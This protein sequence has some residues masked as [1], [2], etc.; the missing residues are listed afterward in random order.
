MLVREVVT[1]ELQAQQEDQTRWSYV[2]REQ[3][4][5]SDYTK[6]VIETKE[7]ALSRIIAE[8]Q[9][10]LT[11]EQ[12]RR[13]DQHLHQIIRNPSELKRQKQ[14]QERDQQKEQQLLAMMPDGFLYEYEGNEGRDVS[15]GFRPN[16]RFRPPTRESEVFHAMQGT[17]IVDGTSKRLKELR[18]RLVRDVVFGWGI[19]GRLRRGGSFDVR[20]GEV[21][22][23]HLELTLVD[24]HITGRALFFKSIGEEQREE[25][26]DFH[27]VPGNLTPA[28]TVEMLKEE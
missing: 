12:Q 8:D 24:V 13:Q 25:R 27:E 23:G 20:Q 17:M 28:Q 5:G 2:S 21:A 11:S 16:P 7:G 19:L 9:H 6:R 3:Q 4:P 18:G 26:S 22:P 10:P 1:N 14:E 15:L